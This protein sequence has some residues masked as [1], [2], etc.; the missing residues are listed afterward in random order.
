MVSVAQLVRAPGCGP[1]GRGFE[2]H[3]PPHIKSAFERKRIFVFIIHFSLLT[4]HQFPFDDF[5]LL[6]NFGSTKY[7]SAVN[8]SQRVTLSEIVNITVF[9]IFSGRNPGFFFKNATEVLERRKTALHRALFQ[10]QKRI[11]HKRPCVFQSD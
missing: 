5:I 4:I 6:I 10:C 1:G 7:G 11:P 2:S 9:S 8:C 3:C